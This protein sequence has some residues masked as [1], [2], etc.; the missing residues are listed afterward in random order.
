M[1]SNLL[2]KS[3]IIRKFNFQMINQLQEWRMLVHIKIILLGQ[4]LGKIKGRIIVDSLRIEVE[5]TIVLGI[6]SKIEE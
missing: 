5:W 6:V 1:L 4:G 2:K 3:L